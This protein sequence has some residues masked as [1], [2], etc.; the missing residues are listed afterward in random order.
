MDPTNTPAPERAHSREV[1]RATLSRRTGALA[2]LA[3]ALLWAPMA[4]VIPFFPDLAGPAEIRI[5]YADHASAMKLILA[6]IAVGFIAF[7]IFVGRLVVELLPRG[8]GWLWTALASALM[9]MTAF[10]MALGVDAA[11]VLLFEA[12]APE[13]VWALHSV[14]FLLAAPGAGAFGTTFFIAMAALTFGG[15]WPRSFGWLAVLAALIN[16]AALGGVFSLAGAVNSGN[17]LGSL[18]GPVVVW[19]VWVVV[20]SVRWLRHPESALNNGP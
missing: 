2:G 11:A 16:L 18:T 3:L 4:L 8:S 15:A 13:I 7:L 10:C 1:V 20:V 17:G 12:V 6:S 5:F 19:L 14:A 9:F